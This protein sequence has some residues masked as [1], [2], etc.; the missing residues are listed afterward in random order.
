[1]I[2]SESRSLLSVAPFQSAPCWAVH[3]ILGTRYTLRH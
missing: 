1:M 2:E 3:L